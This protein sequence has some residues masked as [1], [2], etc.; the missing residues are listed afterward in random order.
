VQC[1]NRDDTQRESKF[2]NPLVDGFQAM[3]GL[4]G[5]LDDGSVSGMT[6]TLVEE[7]D[8]ALSNF[9]SELDK[10]IKLNNKGL[11]CF[12]GNGSAD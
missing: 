5:P 4:L 7:P 3:G 12:R 9:L 8:P 10:M 11:A 1:S 6:A 2:L